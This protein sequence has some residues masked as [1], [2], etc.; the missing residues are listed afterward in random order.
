M[1]ILRPDLNPDSL[2]RTTVFISSVILAVVLIISFALRDYI[3]TALNFT[4]GILGCCILFFIPS[5]EVLKARSLFPVKKSFFNSA[6]WMPYAIIAIGFV[7]MGFN[8]YQTI[9]SLTE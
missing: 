5:M 8:L 7:S 6:V 4:G 2:S 3:Q 9:I 1:A